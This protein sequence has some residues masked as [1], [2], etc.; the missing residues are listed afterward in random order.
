LLGVRPGEGALAFPI[1]ALMLATSLGAAMGGAA[2]EALFFA[3]F[4]LTL[5]PQMYV[6]LGIT[7]FAVTLVISVLF[8]RV[9]RARLYAITPLMLAAVLLAERVLV[10]TGAAWL[11]AA[12]W[13]AMN[14]IVTCQGLVA[15]GVASSLCD[16]R[17]AKRLFP[18][19]NA[20][21]IAGLIVGGL[22]T[23]ALVG[24]L[25]AENL[26]I[27]WAASL[28]GAFALIESLFGR[29]RPVIEDVPTPLSLRDE[30]VTGF[31]VVARSRLLRLLAIAMVLF[32][33][34]YF[35]LALPFSRSVRADL[36]DE[37]R[38]AAFLG[39][40]GGGTTAA[41]LLTSL[42]V[43]NRFYARFGVVNAIVAFVAIYFAGFGVLAA[44]AGAGTALA[45]VTVVRFA[46]MTWLTGVADTAYQALLNPV[47]ADRRDQIR[48]FMEGVP[49][50]AGI[51]LAGVLLLAGDRVLQA[52]QLYV[53]GLV[54]A[55]VTLF[56]MWR[57]RAA[58]RA[59]LSDALRTGRPQPF[60]V[61][62]DP[63]GVLA[64]DP[65]AT[66]IAASGLEDRDLGVR[67]VSTAL[68]ERLATQEHG[69]ALARV[70]SDPEEDE[71]VRASALRALRR[72]APDLAATA[73]RTVAPTAPAR[74]RAEAAVTA[75]DADV[76]AGLVAA[77]ADEAR[78]AALD[79]LATTADRDLR[80]IGLPLVRDRSAT[81]SARAI[82]TFDLYEKDLLPLL[83]DREL[84][85]SLAAIRSLARSGN[86]ELLH[87]F[88][89]RT[90]DLAAADIVAGDPEDPRAALLAE[91]FRQ[92]AMGYA[93][94]AVAAGL[95]LAGRVPDD[96]VVEALA[97]HDGAQRASALE[98]VEAA[99]APEIVRPLLPLWE[100]GDFPRQDVLARARED[101]DPFIQRLA[102]D[103]TDGG[104]R[105]QGLPTLS[106]LD[107]ILFMK[108][109]PLFTMLPPEDLAHVARLATEHVYSEGSVI[110]RE[111][112]RGERL[113]VI[114]SGAVRVIAGERE[115]ARRKEGDYVGELSLITGE[116]RMATLVA[117]GET[118]C[119]AIGRREFEAIIR[120]RPQ[121]GLAV[122]R[123]L[124]ERLREAQ[125]TSRASV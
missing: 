42:F 74:L 125:D 93:L 114:A 75:V 59:A 13:I 77:D 104:A 96:L 5:L 90:R 14:V 30:L 113:Y 86:R 32:S 72:V 21:K 31:R 69:G 65:A 56:L 20:G 58:Y 45:I 98:L 97:Q 48:A 79:A 50:Q 9:D 66:A 2:T 15:W 61:E 62:S 1:T 112:D 118:R 71:D 80:A 27:I 81:I 53:V 29:R 101:P 76:I 4:D 46:Q 85:V 82:E 63:L 83:H 35:S 100:D 115:I 52:W 7:T 28:A 89:R 36:V 49:G 123:T 54:A 91:A 47:P 73:A 95:A 3:R 37:D 10:A 26:L 109:V 122:I 17:Q 57:T 55:A 105:M 34:L 70:A 117:A 22:A 67:R 38:I 94:R 102:A 8:A 60:L 99:V 41:A 51:A 11:Y 16:A 111:G 107:R 24:L 116:P 39:L 25:H 19:F 124:S 40:F 18:L 6:V 119:L 121:V 64:R 43:A 33:V 106:T 23:T 92:R 84:A 78:A 110:A 108:R 12:M 87:A 44:T 88:A 68:M 120:D 103:I